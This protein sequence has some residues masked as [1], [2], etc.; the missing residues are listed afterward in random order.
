MLRR[1]RLRF[2]EVL[3]GN[4]GADESPVIPR[5]ATPGDLLPIVASQAGRYRRAHSSFQTRR[6]LR[7]LIPVQ[8]VRGQR[9]HQFAT[10]QAR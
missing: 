7:L 8:G 2:E 9:R 5:V 4:E 3:S 1:R 10:R 6:D